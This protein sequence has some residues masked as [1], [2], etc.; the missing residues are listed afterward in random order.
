[1]SHFGENSPDPAIR[2]QQK[3]GDWTLEILKCIV[4]RHCRGIWPTHS[5]Q[6]VKGDD[7]ARFSYPFGHSHFIESKESFLKI[8]FNLGAWEKVI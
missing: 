6:V 7:Q 2:T 5:F 3:S 8:P 1:M 4:F